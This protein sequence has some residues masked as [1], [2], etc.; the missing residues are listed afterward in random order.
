MLVNG[1]FLLLSYMNIF[2]LYSSW[3][4]TFALCNLAI[5]AVPHF[6][7]SINSSLELALFSVTVYVAPDPG[8]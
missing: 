2:V 7:N 1:A 4:Y 3:E 6:S 8:E 5:Q